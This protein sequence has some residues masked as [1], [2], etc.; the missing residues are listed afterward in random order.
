[1]AAS[2]LILVPDLAATAAW[3]L[4]QAWNYRCLSISLPQLC[5]QC[6]PLTVTCTHSAESGGKSTGLGNETHL[7]PDS[8]FPPLGK[9][10]EFLF[11]H[12]SNEANRQ[13]TNTQPPSV[14][15]KGQWHLAEHRPWSCLCPFLPPRRT[16]RLIILNPGHPRCMI[17]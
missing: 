14:G 8:G 4:C 16:L 7:G 5:F 2:L 15:V 12:S 3:G 10:T 6:V 13:E 9:V 11:S 1:M 17:L